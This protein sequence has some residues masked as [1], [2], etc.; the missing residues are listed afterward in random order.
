MYVQCQVLVYCLSAPE[1]CVC[2]VNCSP[3]QLG[4]CGGPAGRAATPIQ[5]L[6]PFVVNEP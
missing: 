6:Y 4:C 5:V 3:V 2:L 1:L